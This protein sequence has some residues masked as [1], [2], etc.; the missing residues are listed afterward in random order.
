MSEINNPILISGSL[1]DAYQEVLHWS[2]TEKPA[3][4]IAAQILG[5]FSFIIFGVIFF[6]LAVSLGKL[7][8]HV[9]SGLGE[10]GLVFVGIVLTLVFHELTHGLVMQLFGAKPRYG[11]LWKGLMLY[12]TSPGFA[13]SRNRY[14]VIALAPFVFIST[15]VVLGMWLWQGTLWVALLA[16]CGIF[17]ASGAIGDMWITLIM[18]RYPTTAYVMDERDGIRV[19]LPK[20]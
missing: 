5:V 6:R 15:L 13:Y 11:I 14:I 7:P 2:I 9:E 18:L 19:F 12:A 17:N 16:L 8:A 10:I 20:P 1:P 4:A 3:R